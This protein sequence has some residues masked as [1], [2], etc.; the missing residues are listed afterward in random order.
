MFCLGALAYKY[1]H[2]LTFIKKV[3]LVIILMVYLFVYYLSNSSIGWGNQINLIGYLVLILLVYKLAIT[4]P[5]LSDMI[6]NR[7]DI[8]Y[9]IYIFHMPIVNFLLYKNQTGS[10]GFIIAL[11][12]TIIFAFLSWRF[13]E[14]PF[15]RLKKT[16]VRSN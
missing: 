5:A 14:R 3:P 13:V 16:Q 1:N 9:G 11:I 7:N 12:A 8:S 10:Y 6:L 15:L 4:K 2:L